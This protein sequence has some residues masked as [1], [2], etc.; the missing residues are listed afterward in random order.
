MTVFPTNRCRLDDSF[1][2][3]GMPVIYLENDFL[4]VGI[5]AGRGADIFEIIYKPIGINVLL[6]LDKPIH[7]PATIFSQRRDTL[8]QFEDYYYGG[9]QTILPNS[10]PMNYRG[11]QLGQHGEV[12]QIPWSYAVEEQSDDKIVVK[13]WTSPLRIPIRV[14]KTVEIRRNDSSLYVTESVTNIGQ[15][16]LDIMWGQH[17][18]FGLPW[19]QAGARIETSAQQFKAEPSMPDPRRFAPGQ[20]FQWP[21]GQQSDGMEIDASIIPPAGENPYSELAYLKDFDDTAWYR[22]SDIEGKMSFKL[23]WDRD[24]FKFLWFWQERNATKNAPWW[25]NAYA[26]ALEPWSTPWSPNPQQQ[27]DHGEWISLR[28][29]EV[30]STHLIAHIACQG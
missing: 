8:N 5:L 18:A 30:I 4:K 13:L 20:N 1:A 16:D 21:L 17:I 12:W 26:I 3:N 23:S 14:E 22:I 24:I 7:N 15:T 6:N 9:W 2:M 10:A 25:G 27:I 29:E 19:L 28:A 11:A